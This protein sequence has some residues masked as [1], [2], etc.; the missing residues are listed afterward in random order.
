MAM[1]QVQIIKDTHNKSITAVGYN[2]IK[3]EILA[4][5]EGILI[6]TRRIYSYI[7]QL[8]LLHIITN[9]KHITNLLKCNVIRVQQD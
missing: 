6:V 5:F 4:G 1:E 3:H 7:F 9:F 8:Y 2:P